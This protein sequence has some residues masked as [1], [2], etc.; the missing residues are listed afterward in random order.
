MLTTKAYIT[1]KPEEGDN[2]FKVN[3]PLMADNVSEEAL[4]DALLCS[5]GN[6]NDYNVGDCVFVSFEDDK[7]NTAI[8]LGKLFTDVPKNNTAYGL[9]NE[10]NVTGSV[11]LPEDTKIG[12]Y[13]PQDIF[14][15]YQAA[16]N[17]KEPNLDNLVDNDDLKEYLKSYTS[18]N[19]FNTF[20]G[21]EYFN[22]DYP[23]EKEIV[24]DNNLE[25]G[26]ADKDKLYNKNYN[27]NYKTLKNDLKT[28]LQ[29]RL[30]KF[31]GLENTGQN[32]PSIMQMLFKINSTGSQDYEGAQLHNVDQ[33]PITPIK[34]NY[35][36]N[37]SNLIAHLKSFFSTDLINLISNLKTWVGTSIEEF[38]T[39]TIQPWVKTYVSDYYTNT[40]QPWVK[41][42]VGTWYTNTIQPWVNGNFVRYRKDDDPNNAKIGPKITR[43]MT[44]AD[45]D[46]LAQKDAD[47]M[48]FLT[49]VPP[50]EGN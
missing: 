36:P 16:Q 5:N 14:N 41:N 29:V 17:F 28:F 10:L 20:Y 35:F 21:D 4:F 32:I 34:T 50:S 13:S 7:Y 48:Y 12:Q 43:V 11:T 47:T 1:A 6:Y 9:F 3:I 2:I 22:S 44:G 40:I 23:Y 8:I 38:Y 46:A 18:K 37:Y 45:Y 19:E 39:D 26:T 27:P 30:N 24:F 31:L 49:S 15:L 33:G 42:Y 25:T